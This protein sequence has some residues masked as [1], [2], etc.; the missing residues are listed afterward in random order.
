[1]FDIIFCILAAASLALSVTSIV[2][3]VKNRRKRGDG[4]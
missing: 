1:M 3:Q 4:K 2:L